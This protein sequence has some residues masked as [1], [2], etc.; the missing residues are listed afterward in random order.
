MVGE[1][2]RR[3]GVIKFDMSKDMTL[4]NNREVKVSFFFAMQIKVEA[5]NFSAGVPEQ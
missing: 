3:E 5:V 2:V 1:T 4:D